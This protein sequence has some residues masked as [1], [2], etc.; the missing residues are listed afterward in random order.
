L[1]RNAATAG[2]SVDS[3]SATSVDFSGTFGSAGAASSFQ[4]CMPGRKEHLVRVAASGHVSK[5][6]GST[7]CP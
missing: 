3:D 7:T 5:S 4:L 6:I 2:L 1:Q